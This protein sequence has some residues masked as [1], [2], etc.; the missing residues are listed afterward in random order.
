MRKELSKVYE[1]QEVE[2]RIY[3]QWEENKCFAGIRDAK[4]KPYTI[5]MPP[6]NVT[7]QLHMGHAMDCTLQDILIRFKRMQGYAALWVPG[8]DHAGIA[9]QIKVEEELRVKEGL[10]RYDLGREK[11]LERV[12][13]WKHQY[14]DRIVAQ[15]KK[16]GASCDWDRARFT[17]DEGCSKA[18]RET[19][20]ELYEKGLIY[21]GSR[22]INWC[23]HC[24]TALSDAEVEYVDKPGHLWHMRYPLADGSGYL[25]VATTRPETMMGDTGVAVNPNDERYQH[26]V[27][28]TCILP[29]MN[30][31]IPIVADD[32][33]EM[34][35]GTGCV[36]MTPAHDP[37]DFEVGLR[38]NLET[39]RVLDDNGVVNANG[40]KY[41]GM[42]RYEA[43]KAVVADLE[44]LGLLEKV[45][46]Y[47]HNVGTCYR[48]HN[49]VEPIISAQWFVKMQPL[50]KEA[51]RVVNEGETKFV[52]DRFAKTYTNW[53]ENVHDWCISRQLWWGHQIPV[54]YCDDCGHMTVSRQ[55]PTV[56]EK[57]GSTHIQRD[58]DVLDTWFSSALWPFSTL[59][60]PEKTEDLDYFYPTDVLVTGY[61]IIFF[62]VAR[63]IFSGCEQTKKTPFHTV[64]IHG[65]VRDDQGRKMSKSLGN[66][67]DPLEMAEKYGADALRFNL[68][69]GNSPGND[70]RFYTERC[71]AMRNFANKIWNASRFLMMN[72]TIEDNALPEQLEL[73]DKWILS[74]LNTVIREVTENMDHYEL[75]VAAQ[76]LY[77]FIWDTYCDWYIEMTKARLQGDNPAAKE[78]AQR[79]LQEVD[80]L[81]ADARRRQ[82]ECAELRVALPHATYASYAAVDFLQQAA[83]SEQ[84][85]VHI[86]EAGSMEGLDF[87]LRRGYHLALLRYAEED[88]DYYSRYCARRGLHREQIMEFEYRLLV[89][90]DS[91]LARHEVHDLAELNRYT[92][93]LHDDFQLPGE[94]GSSLRW[95]VNENR[96]VHVY[97]RCSQFSI[98]QSLPTAYMWASPMPQ[99]ALEQY[100]LV[101]KKCPAQNQR[102]RDVLV[103]PDK[104]GLRPEEE[105]FIELLR[106]QAALTVK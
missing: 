29:L 71:E 69:T 78:Q 18:V 44:A 99:R 5:V 32:Y 79:V 33:V 62:W 21:K 31:E 48:C 19:F 84:L 56:C 30:R 97:E 46:D 103:Y 72:L 68:V 45:E 92:E 83:G 8:T 47:S 27:G 75:G 80:R 90:R 34:D 93:V 87:V 70:M 20:C 22:I 101:L 106:R 89:N 59:G 91:P 102:M 65:L 15:Q 96:R 52:P 81:D 57:C 98:L 49:D 12:W 36:K 9:T 4:K 43:R 2:G 104:G 67:I 23:P 26:L 38:H 73:E 40:G 16:L 25:V 105:K 100:H 55:D 85:Q 10:T 94:E 51:L 14:G 42:D 37:N 17:M 1:P 77:D 53:M 61:D 60:W 7:G 64:F 39:I 74:K 58:P 54:W 13:A 82:G 95:Q 76:K 11:F 3:Q 50:A 28:K 24:V 35:F 41:E 6:P 86:R 88:E 63:M 66:G